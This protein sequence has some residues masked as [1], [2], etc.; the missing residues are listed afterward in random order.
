MFKTNMHFFNFS[1]ECNSTS[2]FK[3]LKSIIGRSQVGNR[4]SVSLK[5]LEWRVQEATKQLF[6]YELL[7]P[8]VRN[9]SR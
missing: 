1:F 3:V 5:K 8:S 7:K 2:V 6:H 4:N 9:S